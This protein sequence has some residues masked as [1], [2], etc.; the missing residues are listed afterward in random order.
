MRRRGPFKSLDELAA[1]S[2]ITEQ[3][4]ID[5][6]DN[7]PTWLSISPAKRYRTLDFNSA[8]IDF[9]SAR[10]NLGNL[11]T[12]FSNTVGNVMGYYEQLSL[13]NQLRV[14]Q[15]FEAY[16]FGGQGNS[17]LTPQMIR[18]IHEIYKMARDEYDSQLDMQGKAEELQVDPN[19]GLAT[20]MD[21]LAYVMGQGQPN[22]LPPEQQSSSTDNDYRHRRL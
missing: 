19:I 1:T 8:S 22:Q 17:G 13:E 4:L 5:M 12:A 18:N 20:L 9:N 14:I 15:G 3:Q 16:M 2:A 7:L 6:E 21:G 10:D 11:Y